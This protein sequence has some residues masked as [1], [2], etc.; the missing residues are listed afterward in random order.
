MSEKGANIDLL[1]RNGL[2]DYEVLPP[3]GVWDGIHAAVKVKSRPVIFLRIAAVAAVLLTVGIV[4]YRWSREITNT[5]VSALALNIK[6]AQPVIVVPYDE[7]PVRASIKEQISGNT[8]EVISQSD[9]IASLP[10]GSEISSDPVPVMNIRE[11]R[12]LSILKN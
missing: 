11:A 6:S 5:P 4:T 7:L 3:P 9:N 2:K 8:S 10:D 12:S 1:F